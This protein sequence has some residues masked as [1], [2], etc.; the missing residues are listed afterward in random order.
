LVHQEQHPRFWDKHPSESRK[1][2]IRN[3]NFDTAPDRHLKFDT[4]P[5]RHLHISRF[6]PW[7]R[8]VI[9]CF[10]ASGHECRLAFCQP[11]KVLN[12]D[13]GN[14]FLTRLTLFSIGPSLLFFF[15]YLWSQ[16]LIH[17]SF[18]CSFEATVT[19][20][21]DTSVHVRGIGVC[22]TRCEIRSLWYSCDRTQLY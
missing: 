11:A 21:N 18:A 10:V 15:L 6:S 17:L 13:D 3:L 12:G 1:S 20:Q 4:A 19:V 5:G 22:S 16:F 9:P 7:Y 14:I 8:L 2:K